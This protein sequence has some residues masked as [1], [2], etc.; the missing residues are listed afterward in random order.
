MISGTAIGLPQKMEK[1]QGKGVDVLTV[2]PD[3][4]HKWPG[5]AGPDICFIELRYHLARDV[6][7]SP[8]TQD[9]TFESRE[10]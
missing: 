10:T 3:Y 8:D 7:L 6:I 9:L 2:V 5:I 1:E 4:R